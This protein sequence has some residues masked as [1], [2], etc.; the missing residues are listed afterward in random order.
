MQAAAL[1]DFHSCAPQLVI[2]VHERINEAMKS[3][4]STC[5][6]GILG[7]ASIAKKNW[8]SIVNAGNARIVAVG[9]RSVNNARRF[10]ADCQASVPTPYPVDAVE[11]YDALIQRSDIDALYIPLPTALRTEWAIK[12]AHAG[13]HI[14]IEK[15]CA[16]TAAD[17]QR[18]VDAADASGVQ[19][20]DGVMF[21][22]STRLEAMRRVLDDHTSVGELR[23]I[24]SHFSFV[25]DDEWIHRN[26]V[27]EPAGC[28]GDV[29]WY[30]IRLIQFA[31]NYEMPI[32]VRG[33]I[34]KGVERPDGSGITP[35]EFEGELLFD[36][37][38]SATLYNAF[39]T[40]RQQWAYFSG[41]EGYI[42]MQDFVLPFYGNNV[43]FSVNNDSF[44]G[45]GCFFNL[46]RHKR[47]VSLPEHSNNHRTAQETTL[48][49]TF[50]DL[51]LSA[52]R[53]PFWP[54]V[55]LKTQRV[56]DALLTSAN[57]GSRPVALC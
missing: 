21:M 8:H 39:S 5:R 23:R 11:G 15:P 31:L 24:T 32:E 13:K 6:W 52:R 27:I 44:S 56:M 51:V 46:E 43:E 34:L 3:A 45:G 16:V 49:R 12:A 26:S 40:G 33:R 29:G 36:N 19:F 42:H 55:A 25:A 20:M 17:L 10:I 37:G 2:N 7:S 1:D 9:S 28:L 14:I 30:N 50:S 35:I 41:T 38:V 48:F 22:H 47:T 18:V 4:N 53:D 54:E 57:S